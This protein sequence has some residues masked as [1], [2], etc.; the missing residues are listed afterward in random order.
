M[1]QYF[2]DLGVTDFIKFIKG[3]YAYHLHLPPSPPPHQSQNYD[4]VIIKMIHSAF[5]F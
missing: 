5:I 2:T 4:P 1:Q 3:I